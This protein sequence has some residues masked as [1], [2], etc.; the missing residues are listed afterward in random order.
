[1]FLEQVPNNNFLVTFV[2][3]GK[4]VPETPWAPRVES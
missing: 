2:V 1:M 4:I 3:F